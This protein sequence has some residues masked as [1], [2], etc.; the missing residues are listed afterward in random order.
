MPD[1]AQITRELD[2]DALAALRRAG[3]PEPGPVE[4]KRPL[5]RNGRGAV[6]NPAVRYDRQVTEAFDDGWAFLTEGDELPPLQT[7]LHRDSSKTAIAWNDSPDI[8]F[9]RAVNPYRGCEHG[10]IYCY[11]RPSHAYLGYSPGLEFESQIVFKPDV[12]ALLERELSKP[13]YE[14]RTLAL[15]S[16][17]DP[18]QPVERKY[19]VMRGILEVLERAGHPVGIV[20]K[21]ALILRDLDILTRLA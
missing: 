2:R 14:P 11:A 16:N 6:T 5:A 8:G 7:T 10:C 1:G 13:G 17:T 20:T 21:S 19:Q 12:A 18:Y 15:G 3:E 9:D 4:N